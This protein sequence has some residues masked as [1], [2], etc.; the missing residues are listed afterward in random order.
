MMTT[1]PAG[2]PEPIELSELVIETA[3][4]ALYASVAVGTNPALKPARMPTAVTL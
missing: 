4:L 3:E 2:P 1:K